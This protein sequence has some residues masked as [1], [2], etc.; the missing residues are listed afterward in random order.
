MEE[1]RFK[2]SPGNGNFDSLSFRDLNS[3]VSESFSIREAEGK[4]ILESSL[5][6]ILEIKAH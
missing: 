6:F 2:D 3:Q 4:A 5:D 1:I